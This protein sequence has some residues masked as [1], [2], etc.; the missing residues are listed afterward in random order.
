M[1]FNKL[2]ELSKKPELYEPGDA[3]MW[4]DP[5]ISKQLLKVHLDPELDSATRKQE[6]I[7]KTLNFIKGYCK[8]PEMRILDIGCGPGKYTENLAREGHDVTGMDF[9]ENSIDY[10]RSE[11]IKNNLQIEYLCQ[12]YLE[13]DVQNQ[14]NL[15]IMIYTDFGV[16]IPGDRNTLL[17]KIYNALVP[18][19]IFIFDVINDRNLE[20]KFPGEKAWTVTEGGFWR[21]DKYLELINGFHYPENNVYL[22]QHSIMDED[23]NLVRYR[24]WTH[25]FNDATL[26]PELSEYGFENIESNINVLPQGDVWNGENITFYKM[27]KPVNKDK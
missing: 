16:L 10:A 14:Y 8:N 25:Y 5:Y 19:G 12:N 3:M 6:S 1:N 9:S 15:I 27:N 21:P 4:T 24:F 20:D 2:S 11:A 7:D 13:L 18:G 17:C 22:M 23:E 26:I